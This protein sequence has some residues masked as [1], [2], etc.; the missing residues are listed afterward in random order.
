MLIV[1]LFIMQW[2]TPPKPIT[3][4]EYFELANYIQHEEFNQTLDAILIPR[5]PGTRGHQTVKEVFNLV[6]F[7]VNDDFLN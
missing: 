4:Q 5:V 3:D 1:I 7:Q 2:S 6:N